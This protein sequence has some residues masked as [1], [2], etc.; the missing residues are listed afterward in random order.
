MERWRVM[1]WMAVDRLYRERRWA[2]RAAERRARGVLKVLE[3]VG[4][5]PSGWG[6]DGVEGGMQPSTARLMAVS[7]ALAAVSRW[8][9][10]VALRG[11]RVGEER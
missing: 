3:Q 11:I 9:R 4:R 5:C 2:E 7:S 1:C 10:I 6:G 8:C